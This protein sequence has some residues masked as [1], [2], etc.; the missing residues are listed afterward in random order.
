MLM[1][2]IGYLFALNFADKHSKQRGKS[3]RERFPNPSSFRPACSLSILTVKFR[4]EKCFFFVFFTGKSH[5]LGNCSVISP[6]HQ[7]YHHLHWMG[8]GV[9][10]ASLLTPTPVARGYAD[11]QID[12]S[13]IS[14]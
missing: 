6:Q 12:A 1:V 13:K 10:N 2:C 11:A 14:W 7:G 5:L 4:K 8:G 9:Q 3:V